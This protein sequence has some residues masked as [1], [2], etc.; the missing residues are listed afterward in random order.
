MSNLSVFNF[1]SHDIRFVGTA[2]NPWWIASDV[3]KAIGLTNTSQSM[4]R[5]IDSEKGYI[6]VDTLGGKQKLLA[7]NE[8]G[9]YGLIFASRKESAVRFRVYITSE[10]I[11]AIRKTGTYSTPT[12]TAKQPTSL[13]LV[14]TSKLIALT[15]RELELQAV[16]KQ[17]E[18]LINTT[19]AELQSIRTEKVAI[20]K[21]FALAHPDVVS[22]A[23]KCS[24]IL[25]AYGD[26]NKYFSNPLKK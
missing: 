9:L 13:T 21:A 20:A 19:K 3:C 6:E 24:E 14:D 25:G 8:S 12:T 11:P 18:S 23:L 17:Y 10:V 15:D 26:G 16:I 1:E 7:V 22:H 5:L 4:E 2:D